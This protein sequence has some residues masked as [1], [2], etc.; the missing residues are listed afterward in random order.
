MEQRIFN[1]VINSLNQKWQQ[2]EWAKNVS[3]YVVITRRWMIVH[4]VHVLKCKEREFIY[5]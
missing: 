3:I 1:R 5:M 4:I 2:N